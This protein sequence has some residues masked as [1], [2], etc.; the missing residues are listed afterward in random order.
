MSEI[1]LR[2]LYVV[3]M[4][5]SCSSLRDLES[6]RV[7]RTA[8]LPST[9]CQPAGRERPPPDLQGDFGDGGLGPEASTVGGFSG[10]D[11]GDG[12]AETGPA[13]SSSR[14]GVGIRL[15]KIG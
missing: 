12:G 2:A 9:E 15:N 7:K 4:R 14:A 1:L 13:G 5:A 11:G 8:G 6:R 3:M 10:G